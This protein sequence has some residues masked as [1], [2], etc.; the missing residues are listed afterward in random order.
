MKIT[1]PIS[2]G[3]LYDKISILEIKLGNMDAP[4]KIANVAKELKELLEISKEYPI[5]DEDYQKLKNVN[6]RIW[7]IE[8]GIREEEKNKRWDADFIEFAR[9]VYF[10]NDKRSMIKKEINLRYGS[11]FIEEKSYQRY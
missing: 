10:N 6:Q 5:M 8:D 1:I 7:E 11:D 2:F 4:D 3:E 9:Q